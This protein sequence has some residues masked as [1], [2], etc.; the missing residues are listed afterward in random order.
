MPRKTIQCAGAGCD[1]RCS[2]WYVRDDVA[3]CGRCTL[4]ALE[5]ERLIERQGVA[6]A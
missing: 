5:A 4:I 3:R 1:K 2:V 6:R